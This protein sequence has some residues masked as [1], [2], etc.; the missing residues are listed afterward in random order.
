MA[1]IFLTGMTASQCSHAVNERSLNFAGVMYKVLTSAG[2]DVVWG[3]P[4]VFMPKDYF[5]SFDAVVV[6]VSPATSLSSNRIYGALS[7]ISELKNSNK[8]TLF[9]DVPTVRQI[10]ISFKSFIS[11]TENI[12]KSFFSSRKEYGSVVGDSKI[13][14][15]VLDGG[16]YIANENWC[17]TVYPALPWKT[18]ESIKLPPN[19][20]A[21]LHKINLDS[22]FVSDEISLVERVE[23]WLC[24]SPNSKWAS[25]LSQHVSMPI[26]PMKTDKSTTDDQVMEQMLRS[27]GV[28]I[29]PDQ[30]D[31]TYW[32][33][34]YIQAINAGVPIV[35]DWQESHVISD[36]WGVLAYN[37]DVAHEPRR[38]FIALA[39]RESYIKRIP[40]KR[41]SLEMLEIAIQV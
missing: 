28:M 8:L 31:G 25:N 15:R 10:G 38:D 2:H 20:K 3:N 19:A 37:I 24:D 16:K 33:Y 22:H 26:V 17:R 12:T 39:Q 4:S 32:S 18:T 29:A 7:I 40:S 27:S 6:G 21:N 34:R 30:K 13:L 9:V 5:D 35:T 41:K 14:E 11:N 1:K 23:K 36:S